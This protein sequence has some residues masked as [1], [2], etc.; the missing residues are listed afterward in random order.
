MWRRGVI[1]V[2]GSGSWSGREKHIKV[3]QGLTAYPVG[4]VKATIE[5]KKQEREKE[6]EIQYLAAE[7]KL[8]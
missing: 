6:D 8:V 3:H 1:N 5:K 7:K 4:M 2:T